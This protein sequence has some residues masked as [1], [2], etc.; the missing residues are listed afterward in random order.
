M[1]LEAELYVFIGLST[2]KAKIYVKSTRKCTTVNY[3]YYL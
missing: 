1:L 3:K 2:A